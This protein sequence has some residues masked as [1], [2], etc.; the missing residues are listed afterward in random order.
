MCS[1]CRPSDGF[2]GGP[3]AEIGEPSVVVADDRSGPVAVGGDVGSLQ[4]S[5]SG[6]ATGGWSGH[7][8][9][10]YEPDGLRCRLRC[11]HLLRSSMP[12]RSLAFHP[13]LPLPAVATG[14]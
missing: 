11:R 4:W 14:S 9:G 2:G 7:R 3:F 13:V 6:T 1:L 10:V 5:G 12:V 8:I